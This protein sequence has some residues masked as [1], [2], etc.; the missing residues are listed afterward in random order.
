MVVRTTCFFVLALL[1][2]FSEVPGVPRAMAQ[3]LPQPRSS[4]L[5]AGALTGSQV[6][7]AVSNVVD[8][9]SP[10]PPQVTYGKGRLA[11]L[12]HN[13]TLRATLEEIG[14]QTGVDIDIPSEAEERVAMDLSGPP[15][16]VL[17]SLLDGSKFGYVILGFAQDP[18]GIQKI[19]LTNRELGAAGKTETAWAGAGVEARNFPSSRVAAEPLSPGQSDSGENGEAQPGLSAAAAIGEALPSESPESPLHL[20]G[21]DPNQVLQAQ[22]PGSQDSQDNSQPKMN[23]G[24]QYMQ[25][26]YRLRQSAPPPPPPH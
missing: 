21:P 25:E 7:P 26:L 10:E 19:V 20:A 22:Q 2:S 17:A 8:Q 13:S 18:A 3:S 24:G 11:V 15:R 23:P 6:S 4:A 14:R 1:A 9:V 16:D 12:A 5:P